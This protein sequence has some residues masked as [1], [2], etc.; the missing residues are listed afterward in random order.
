MSAGDSPV[1]PLTVWGKAGFAS[2][3]GRR[4]KVEA[5]IHS[6]VTADR[7]RPKTAT[8]ASSA[9]QRPA[10]GPRIGAIHFRHPPCRLATRTAPDSAST[11]MAS[12]PVAVT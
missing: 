8:R 4:S 7:P 2:S 6:A 9:C 1:T 5:A 12:A 3:T 11:S 10:R